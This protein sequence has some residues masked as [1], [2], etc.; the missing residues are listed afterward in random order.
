MFGELTDR[1]DG[2]FR[3]LRGIGKLSEENIKDS[4]KE[5]GST[6]SVIDA[7]RC[8]DSRQAAVYDTGRRWHAETPS[9]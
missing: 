8:I 4:L 3:N 6:G 7:F 1:L 2:L 9:V 5:V